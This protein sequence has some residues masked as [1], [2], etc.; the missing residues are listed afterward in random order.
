[1]GGRG[2][3]AGGRSRPRVV[4]IVA[5][6]RLLAVV[7]GGSMRAAV[8]ALVAGGFQWRNVSGG[9]ARFCHSY[10]RRCNKA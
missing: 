10:A 8:A 2:L 1:V 7:P 3:M 5:R 6:T 9:S 4:T